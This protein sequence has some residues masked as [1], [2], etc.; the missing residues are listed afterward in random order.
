MFIVS[1]KSLGQNWEKVEKHQKVSSTFCLQRTSDGPGSLNCPKKWFQLLSATP[2]KICF[3]LL[4]CSVNPNL[5]GVLQKGYSPGG[6]FGANLQELNIP[7]YSIGQKL[8]HRLL[9]G[10]KKLSLARDMPIWSLRCTLGPS[11]GPKWIFG[12]KIFIFSLI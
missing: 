9:N 10:F 1:W 12:S 6:S 4:W 5:P 3:V 7:S 11:E 2:Y 8:S